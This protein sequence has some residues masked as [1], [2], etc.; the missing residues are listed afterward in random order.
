[1]EKIN[2][3]PLEGIINNSNLSM[4]EALI[5]FVDYPMKLPLALLIKFQEIQL[6]INFFHFQNN[7]SKYGLHNSNNDPIQILSSLFGISPDLLKT[8]MTLSETMSDSFSPDI[9]SGLSGNSTSDFSNITNLFQQNFPKNETHNPTS[10][11]NNSSMQK[12]DNDSDDFDKNIQQILSS[13]D[14]NQAETLNHENNPSP[15]NN[16]NK[17]TNDI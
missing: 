9:L 17:I 15:S 11:K 10:P 7:L 3:H 4:L 12:K 16:K 14:L 6:I 2:H 5:P 1:M 8:M 13:Y